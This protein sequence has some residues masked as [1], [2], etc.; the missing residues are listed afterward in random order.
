MP[1]VLKVKGLTPLVQGGDTSFSHVIR[2]KGHKVL[3]VP[4]INQNYLKLGLFVLILIL[5]IGIT[6]SVI[7]GAISDAII[8]AF[9][10]GVIAI[11]INKGKGAAITELDTQSH[12]ITTRIDGGTITTAF[13]SVEYVEVICKLK[14]AG[15]ALVTKSNELNIACHKGERFNLST[16]G[17]NEVIMA[18]ANRVAKTL[19]VNIHVDEAQKYR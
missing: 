18:Q 17:D 19:N 4:R 5:I 8:L 3:L 13:D 1:K 6:R 11:F 7:S 14:Y 10:C 9:I 12:A 16:G 15:N 2:T